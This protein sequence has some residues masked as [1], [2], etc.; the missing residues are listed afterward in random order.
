MDVAVQHGDRTEA[1][2][3]VERALTIFGA[4]A[5]FLVEDIERDMGEDHD[6]RAV[7]LAFQISFEPG[8]LL[9]AE[10]AEAAALQVDDI[11]EA[12]EVNAVIIEGIPACALRALAVAIEIGLAPVFID[13][14]V[15]TGNPMR[16]Q[17][18]LAE[19]LVGIVELGGL[20]EVGDVAG[21]D[22]E[23]RLGLHRLDLGDR[24]TKRTQSVRIGCLVEADVAVA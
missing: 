4:P 22:D 17:A 1:L 9:G 3:Q 7:R 2:E 19:Y 11:D 24:F 21:M 10:I 8:E 6:R 13:D 23:S 14:V 15:L 5:P 20:G 16:L 12:D 18:G